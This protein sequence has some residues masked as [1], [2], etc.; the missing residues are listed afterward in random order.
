MTQEVKKINENLIEIVFDKDSLKENKRAKQI[1]VLLFFTGAYATFAVFFILFFLFFEAY[2]FFME[3]PINE[4]F[5]EDLWA[6]IEADNEETRFG[7]FNIIW[8]SIL[9]T[10]GAMVVSI[11]LGIGTAIYIAEIA[12]PRVARFM[13]SAVEILSG[14]PS[15][16]FGYFGRIVLSLW[17]MDFFDLAGGTSW[18]AGSLVLGFMALP[19]IVS[20]SEDAIST[21]PKEFKEGSLA[22]GATK[23]QTIIKVVLPA[24]ISGIAA[25]IMLGIGRAIGETMAVVMITGNKNVLPL[26][27][28]NVFSGVRTITGAIALEMGEALGTHKTALFALAVVLFMM[29]FIVNTSANY[30]MLRLQNKFQATQKKSRFSILSDLTNDQKMIAQKILRIG[31]IVSLSLCILL[32]IINFPLYWEFYQGEYGLA[33]FLD[34]DTIISEKGV[35]VVWNLVFLLITL[36]LY[37][38]YKKTMDLETRG[39]LNALTR[40]VLMGLIIATIFLVLNSWFEILEY[41]SGFMMASLI[42]VLILGFVV[43][44]RLVKPEHQQKLGY[45]LVYATT[46][47]VLG[48]L[49]LIISNI[50]VNGI[51]AL[52]NFTN[53][54]GV[55]IPSGLR[56]EFFTES[57]RDL[58]RRGG[59]FPA[60]IGTIFLTVGAIFYAIPIGLGAGIYLAEYTKEG[61]ITKVI[62]SGIDNLNGTPSIVFGLFGFAFFILF[63]E[64][65]ISMF[66]GQLVLA[67]MIMPTIIRTTEEA[68]KA[69]PQGFREGSLALGATKWQTIRKVVLPSAIPGVITGVILGMGRAIGETAPIMFVAVVF[70][71]RYLPTKVI[72]PVSALTFHLFVL[73]KE[74]P[75]AEVKAA[76]TALILLMVVLALY[77]VGIII[78]NYFKKK[79]KW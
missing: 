15:I 68:I 72:E 35:P 36:L 49:V 24:S 3:Y 12:P 10:F 19:T 51:P 62:R 18:L 54:N 8:G 76:G 23:W 75:N 39:K 16:V 77:S 42:T 70:S 64:F 26:P 14:I 74:V 33:A 28:T 11:P 9:V 25:A 31:L 66:V 79:K 58:G 2:N 60:L 48:G 55:R 13:K 30:I 47:I 65:P 29:T 20:V 52:F 43:I 32:F 45:F 40:T 57:P 71:Q 53:V 22:M 50:V 67:M 34:T 1:K 44:Y 17:L 27:I 46:F 78:R 37:N 21:V 63:L 59:I 7:A 41:S 69:I 61:K 5:L 6:P 73:L 56:T 4:F 38:S